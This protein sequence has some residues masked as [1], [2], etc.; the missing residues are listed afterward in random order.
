MILQCMQWK[1][2]LEFPKN[3][4]SGDDQFDTGDL[5]LLVNPKQNINCHNLEKHNEDLLLMDDEDDIIIPFH[6]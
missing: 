5:H 1:I 6:I 2:L 4:F 3:I